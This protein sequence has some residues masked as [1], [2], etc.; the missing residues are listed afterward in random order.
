MGIGESISTD[1]MKAK[2]ENLSEYMSGQHQI[3]YD[4]AKYLAKTLNPHLVPMGFNMAFELAMHDVRAGVDP[5]TNEPL[6]S[7]LTGQPAPVYTI[8]SMNLPDIADAVC[9]EDFAKGVREMYDEIQ[10]EMKK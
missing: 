5:R 9:P 2:L 7:S 3:V 1:E 4:F 10:E 8:I 6:P